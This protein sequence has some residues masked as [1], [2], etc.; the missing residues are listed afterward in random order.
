MVGAVK[1]WFTV[2]EASAGGGK[3]QVPTGYVPLVEIVELDPGL[4]VLVDGNGLYGEALLLDVAAATTVADDV[5]SAVGC[6]GETM[7]TH[8]SA[9]D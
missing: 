7:V 8:V 2:S 6:V 9:D 4:V 5:L 1:A 3:A